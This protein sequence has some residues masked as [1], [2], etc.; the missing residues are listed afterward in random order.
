[1]KKF[2][3]LLSIFM[4]FVLLVQI[5]ALPS[6]YGIASDTTATDS[7]NEKSYEAMLNAIVGENDMYPNEDGIWINEFSQEYFLSIVTNLSDQSYT[8]NQDG[9]LI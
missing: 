2:K 3:N 9:Y 1:M 5:I 6:A 4:S 7:D 8:V